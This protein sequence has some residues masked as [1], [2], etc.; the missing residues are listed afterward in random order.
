MIRRLSI[1]CFLFSAACSAPAASPPPTESQTTSSGGE[2]NTA[3]PEQPQSDPTVAVGPAILAVP[4]P[5]V[6]RG[7][8]RPE[9][10]QLWISV[11]HAAA[12]I[13]PDPPASGSDEAITNWVV[14]PFTGWIRERVTA[15]RA[16]AAIAGQLTDLT[17]VERGFAATLIA[18]AFEDMAA[19]ARGAVVPDWITADPD[20][21]RIYA[22]AIERALYPVADL[23]AVGYGGC[24]QLFTEAN[25]PAW[26]EWAPY[27]GVHLEDLREVFGRY[28]RRDA[29]PQ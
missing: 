21:I 17:L 9:L 27:C 11:E 14:G 3:A 4:L 1:A 25:E 12:I 20:L 10:Q 13:A 6:P 5:G 22:E 2:A 26:N 7:E 29:D 15:T 28:A 24:V 23:A 19:S 18:F 16:A 8:L